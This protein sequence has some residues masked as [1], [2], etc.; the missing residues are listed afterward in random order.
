[1]KTRKPISTISYNTESFLSY[2]LDELI[3]SKVISYWCYVYHLPEDDETKPHF[4]VLMYPNGQVDTVDIQRFF[5][6]L[7]FNNSKP[8]GMIYFV[9]SVPDEW[10]LYCSHNSEY[11]ASKCQSRKHCYNYDDFYSSD[12][13]SFEFDWHHAFNCML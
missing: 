10:Y 1:M 12:F 8:L 11:L 3:K 6:E 13:N 7:D 9:N 4:H 2:K 5:E